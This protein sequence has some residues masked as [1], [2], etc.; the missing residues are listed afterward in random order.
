MHFSATTFILS[1]SKYFAS[2]PDTQASKTVSDT[3]TND[4]ANEALMEEEVIVEVLTTQGS[5]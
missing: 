4:D 1:F 3:E 2:S 5:C